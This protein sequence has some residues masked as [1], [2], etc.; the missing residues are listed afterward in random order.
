MDAALLKN[1]HPLNTLSPKGLQTLS[2]GMQTRQF[3]SGS[4]IF[5]IG[6]SVYDTL[7]VLEGKVELLGGDGK[8]KLTLGIDKSKGLHPFPH[9]VPSRY[10]ARASGD[11]KLL[12]VDSQLLS[13]VLS[14]DQPSGIE[15]GRLDASE[16]PAADWMS[17]FLAT[18][19]FSRVPPA[20]LQTVFVK[21]Q[22]VDV[23]AGDIVIKQGTAGD[24]FFVIARGK[25]VVEREA[26][27][28][29]QPVKLAEFGPG[30]C[31]GED[32]LISGSERNATVR[33]L[34][35]GKLMKLEK[36][37]FIA[38]LK[39]PLI[40]EVSFQ[41]AK[42]MVAKGGQWVDVRMPNEVN[43]DRVDGSLNIPFPI[44]RTR[45]TTLPEGKP[46]V[47]F[48]KDGRNSSTGT[49]LL[50]KQGL[51]AYLLRGGIDNATKA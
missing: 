21:M 28:L 14:W 17:N 2:K 7:Y 27:N 5:R 22:S 26:A 44:L 20:K 8:L 15:V 51:E 41:Q 43:N 12:Q 48:C 9:E 46:Y 23:K 38:L 25:V 50:S 30:S 47:V 3:K 18:R 45:L 1:I 33:M 42:D 37:D 32:A 4:F 13:S 40:P 6:E 29:P 10:D 24:C 31:F 16:E 19:G 11:V 39:A 36:P 49:F 34:T 35:D